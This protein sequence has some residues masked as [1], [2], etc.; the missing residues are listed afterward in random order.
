[1]I[2]IEGHYTQYFPRKDEVTWFLKGNSQPTI[3]TDLFPPQQQQM[4]SQN[5]VPL[6]GG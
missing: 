2:C 3:L 4:I 5:F 6:Q 1:M